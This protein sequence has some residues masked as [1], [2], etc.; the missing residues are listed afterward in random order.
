MTSRETALI[1]MLACG[2]FD[3]LITTGLG[4]AGLSLDRRGDLSDGECQWSCGV[5]IALQWRPLRAVWVGG[6]F[7][8][9][10]REASLAEVMQGVWSGN[11]PALC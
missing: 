11:G 1:R 9:P 7:R 3:Y 10:L 2:A 6:G 5:D 8:G 4:L